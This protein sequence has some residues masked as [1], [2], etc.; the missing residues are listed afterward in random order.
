MRHFKFSVN[1]FIFFSLIINFVKYMNIWSQ[2]S[3]YVIVYKMGYE[4][5]S[6]QRHWFW[7]TPG[8]RKEWINKKK[9]Q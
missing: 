1:Y 4:I 3:F 8:P 2:N 5:F 9:L 6:F 7:L